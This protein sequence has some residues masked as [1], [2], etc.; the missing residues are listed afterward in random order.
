LHISARQERSFKQQAV[1]E[2]FTPKLIFSAATTCERDCALI[3]G[4]R[5]TFSV[6]IVHNT[7]E[8]IILVRKYA[9]AFLVTL[10]AHALLHHSGDRSK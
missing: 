9:I 5:T 7:P 4:I 3:V 2:E 8:S 1:V 6:V 10:G